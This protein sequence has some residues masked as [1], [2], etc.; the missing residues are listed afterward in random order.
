MLHAY[1]AY[2]DRAGKPVSECRAAAACEVIDK[3]G[4]DPRMCPI[5]AVCLL[6]RTPR[7]DYLSRNT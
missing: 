6:L 4:E 7:R 3:G 5:E 1:A 2:R